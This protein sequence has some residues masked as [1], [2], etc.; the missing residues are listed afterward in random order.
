VEPNRFIDSLA[1]W[2]INLEIL[3]R[4]PAAHALVLKVSVKAFG[5]ALVLCRV[6]DEA[7][8]ELDRLV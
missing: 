4:K 2:I 5:E 7:G 3:R 6:A 1:E 8:V